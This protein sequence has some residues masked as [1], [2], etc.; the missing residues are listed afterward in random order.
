MRV[1]VTGVTGFVGSALAESLMRDGAAVVGLARDPE[2]ARSALGSKI[3]DA[4][5]YDDPNAFA[6]VRAIVHLAGESVS[7]LWTAKKR[8]R[9]EKS[10]IEGTRALVDAIER[11]AVRP[12]VLVS[13]SAVGYY[14]DPGGEGPITEKHARG[15]GFLAEVCEGWEREA[16]RAEALGLRVVR[17]RIGIVLGRGGGALEAML[18]SFKLGLG[19]RMGSGRQIWPWIHLADLVSMIR[20]AIDDTTW[21]GV[22]NATAPEPVT[23]L[24]FTKTLASLLRRPS[25]L[26]A[27]AFALETVLG[28]F[29][30]ELLASRRVLP[31]RALDAGFTFRFP[32]LEPALR[33]LVAR[34]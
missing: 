9:I 23:Q 18:P 25:F 16:L 11:C 1:L 19:G 26:P 5:S 8:E 21:S 14:G 20:R 24:V 2:R 31:Q 28:D 17:L 13:A 4:Y 15:K 32:K 29:A 6:D 30:S 34:R 27:P 3:A 12:S 10:R 33:E 22:Y 7:G